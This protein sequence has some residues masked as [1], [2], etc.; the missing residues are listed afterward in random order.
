MNMKKYK[1]PLIVFGLLALAAI[2]SFLHPGVGMGVGVMG[3]A[4]GTRFFGPNEPNTF[5]GKGIKSGADQAL[6]VPIPYAAT[7]ALPVPSRKALR[8]YVD[9]ALLTGALTVNATDVTQ[10]QEGDELIMQFTV[11][12]TGRTVTWG[13]NF[14]TGVAGTFAMTASQH[15]MVKAVFMNSKW[16]IYSQTAGAA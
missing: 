16:H 2:I 8:H 6:G 7:I 15:G 10:Y 11:D 12:A 4:F 3:M 13:T 5:D 9:F 1:F 14:R